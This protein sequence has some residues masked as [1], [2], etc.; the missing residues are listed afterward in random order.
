MKIIITVLYA[1]VFGMNLSRMPL[2]IQET[3]ES[4]QQINNLKFLEILKN[5]N[6][7]VTRFFE[8]S[9]I[10]YIPENV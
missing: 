5:R 6:Y 2:D 4:T 7:F 10:V 8:K 3:E 9:V 1:M